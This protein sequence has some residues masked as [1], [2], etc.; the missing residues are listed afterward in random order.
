M[1]LILVE[2]TVELFHPPHS[3]APYTYTACCVNIFDVGFVIRLTSWSPCLSHADWCLQSDVVPDSTSSGLE[4]E[5]R[6][7]V[8]GNWMAGDTRVIVATIAFGKAGGV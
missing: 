7:R 2:S 5:H 1:I 3:Q 6:A 8:Q 4:Y